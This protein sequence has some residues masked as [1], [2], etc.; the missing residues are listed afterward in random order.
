MALQ[1]CSSK[2]MG[3]LLMQTCYIP[4]Y[5]RGYMWGEDELK[6]FLDDVMSISLISDRKE[7][8][9]GQMVVHNDNGIKNIVDGQQRMVTSVCFVKA[10]KMLFDELDKNAQD[11]E[12]KSLAHDASEDIKAAYIGRI[13]ALKNDAHLILQKCDR[14]FFL[15]NIQMD[16]VK[17]DTE[18]KSNVS[19]KNMIFALEYFH[20]CIRI[21]AWK[22]NDEKAIFNYINT[23]LEDFLKKTSVLYLESN[24]EGQAC[25]I[26][27][28]LN[29]RGKNLSPADLIKNYFFRS[30]VSEVN[31]KWSAITSNVET[32]YLTQFINYYF[33]A[34]YRYVQQKDLF[35]S[36]TQ[37]VK[38][39]ENVE[40]MVNE[41][42]FLSKVY[43]SARHIDYFSVFS[44]KRVNSALSALQSMKVTCFYPV[45]FSLAL[46]DKYTEMD[47]AV[48]MEQ[49]EKMSFRTFSIC[50]RNSNIFEKPF[51][52]IAVKINNGQ[53]S[54]VR[55]I[56]S[57]IKEIDVSDEEFKNCFIVFT[58][59]YSPLIKYIMNKVNN[60]LDKNSELDLSGSK[61]HIEHV[62]P[63][64]NSVWNVSDEVHDT[65]LWRL[66]NLTL[67]NSS[68][69]ESASN[70]TFEEKKK[71]YAQSKIKL[72]EYICS[73][74][75]W[76]ASSI[77]K[78]QLY[79]T[80]IALR[81]WD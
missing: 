21:E 66:G 13:N 20:R 27:E 44:N 12:I 16:S 6:D 18:N 67:L 71:E 68:L 79:L 62:M 58:A 50:R 46:N 65:Y 2:T 56:V 39:K 9:F 53:L 15:R 34:R 23:L 54:N 42:V 22:R 64:N 30:G 73:F 25:T 72:N 14:E 75:K 35:R 48:V 36:I 3:E 52:D 61:T 32:A 37:R 69:N 47:M 60:Y 81:I 78:R 45:V 31:E 40:K 8:F 80:D 51:S 76:D 59:Q 55:D 29:A 28:T 57:K 11:E 19:R 63:R 24:D 7:H 26:F 74:D 77:E 43:K 5:Q 41:L 10:I 49:F 70:K 17:R 38:G 4:E 33:R 1:N